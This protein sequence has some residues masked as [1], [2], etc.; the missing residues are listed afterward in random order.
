MNE[1]T[2]NKIVNDFLNNIKKHTRLNTRMSFDF[3]MVANRKIWHG[4]IDIRF[5]ESM[6][7]LR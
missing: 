6:E 5:D 2:S 1:E 4:H 3:E 7:D